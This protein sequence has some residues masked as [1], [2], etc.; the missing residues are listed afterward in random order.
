M[1]IIR[2][3]EQVGAGLIFHLKRFAVLAEIARRIV[4]GFE[5]HDPDQFQILGFRILEDGV[6]VAVPRGRN[7]LPGPACGDR[8]ET[9]R[10]SER[11]PDAPRTRGREQRR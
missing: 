4:V 2:A 3:A 9:V 7:G 11:R 10:R 1:K 8:R 5:R 6:A